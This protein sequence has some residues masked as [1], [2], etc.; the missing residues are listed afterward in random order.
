MHKSFTFFF[1]IAILIAGC[2][3]DDKPVD[4]KAKPEQPSVETPEFNADSAYAYIQKQVDFGPR[5]PNTEAHRAC[6]NWLADEL[7][8]YGADVITQEDIVYAWDGTPLEM[9]NIIGQFSPGKKKRVMLYAHWDTRP[10][11]DKDS[12][13]TQEPIAGA[14]DGGSGVG[15]LLEVARQLSMQ[16]TDVGIDIIFFDTE[17]YGPPEWKENEQDDFKFWCL[18]SQYWTENKHKAGYRAKY[19]ILLDMVGGKNA[20]FNREGTSMALAPNVVDHVWRIARRLGYGVLF[21]DEVTP[22]TIDDNYFV[23]YFGDV[24]SANIVE[25]H[26]DV[27]P[28]VRSMGY[29]LFHHTHKDDMSIIDVARLRAVGETVMEVIYLE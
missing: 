23:S 25:Y 4:R 6:G 3:E 26:V 9:K 5:V 29:G 18:G 20:V 15:V 16:P 1:F 8:K 19:G 14:N 12:T 21:R 2:A 10:Y 11:A 27:N 13:R 28:E 22:Q 17:D 24:P 7:K